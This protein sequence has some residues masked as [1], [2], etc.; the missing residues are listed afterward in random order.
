MEFMRIPDG[1]G[2]V[3]PYISVEDAPAYI[4]FL[5][6][7]MGAVELGRSVLP[8][9]R[10]ANCQLRIGTTGIMLSEALEPFSPS[11]SSFYLYVENAETAMQLA[12][13]AGAVQIMAIADMPYGDR[14]GGIKDPAGNLWWISERL[15]DAPY[16]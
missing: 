9:G 15:T 8:D 6:R 14:Q 3:T 16:Y 4:D 7:G 2:V 12:L 13:A 11:K 5:I 1:F 10:I